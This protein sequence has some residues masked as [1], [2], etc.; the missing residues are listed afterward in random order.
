MKISTW[1][2]FWVDKIRRVSLDYLS[3]LSFFTYY[4]LQLLYVKRWQDQILKYTPQVVELIKTDNYSLIHQVSEYKLFTIMGS[5]YS[6]LNLFTVK[7]I[8]YSWYLLMFIHY[9]LLV[10]LKKE[11]AFSVV[12]YIHPTLPIGII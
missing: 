1:I 6:I 7:F 3:C 10:N 9:D 4:F 12:H 8:F 2:R 5:K 11:L